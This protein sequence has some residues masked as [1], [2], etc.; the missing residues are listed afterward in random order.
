MFER[1]LTDAMFLKRWNIVRVLVS[2][3]VAE[4]TFAVAHYAN[5]I[6]TILGLDT[7]THLAVLQY[8]LWHDVKDEIFTSDLPG[9]NKRGLLD[10]IGP[11]AKVKWDAK[12]KEWANMVFSNLLQRSGG[13][14][15]PD[16]AATIK[17]TVKVA[18]WLEAAV[19]MANE[20]QMGNRCAHRHVNPNMNGA[21]ET[22]K[23]LV[24]HHT[25]E[26]TVQFVTEPITA[27]EILYKHLHQC[28][29]A[30]VGH[31]RHSQS[32]GPWITKEDD[33][34]SYTDAAIGDKSL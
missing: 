23:L 4:H 17:L 11:E 29:I 13:A 6:C 9:P 20:E 16:V 3:S 34:R 8:A 7:T 12:L 21:L 10:A 32:R 1:E 27:G 31:A 5:D 2:Q 14:H 22:A 26:R 18:D 19:H 25:G 24:E 28:I 33:S 15:M 30:A